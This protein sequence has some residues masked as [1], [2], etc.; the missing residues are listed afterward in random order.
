MFSIRA[1]RAP[2]VDTNEFLPWV[3]KYRPKTVDD[4]AY[5]EDVIATLKRSV[6]TQNLPHLLF[7]GPP[8]TGKTS[9][10]LAIGR[11]LFGGDLYKSRILELNA[12]DDRGINVIRTKIKNFSQLTSRSTSSK[13]PPYK[14]LILDE[15]DSMTPEAQAALRRTME[16]YSKTTR[17]CL[18]CNYVSRIIEPLASRCAKFRFKP[19]NTSSMQLRLKTICEQEGITFTTELG[20]KLSEVSGGDMR[21]AITTLQSAFTLYGKD[22]NVDMVIDISG[23]V[24]DKVIEDLIKSATSFSF[25]RL[26]KAVNDVIAEGYPAMQI[27]SQIFDVVVTSPQLT[28]VHKANIAEA[29]AQA[30]KNLQ[31]GADESLQ[32]M[33]VL[34]V[35]LKESSNKSH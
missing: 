14:L 3:E 26:Q 5:Q 20:N 8:G 15:A 32:L 9:T 10:I 29:L 4:V 1:P 6:E 18:I 28:N 23:L 22:V 24:P 27:L 17:F 30:D 12:S 16:H 33:S 7:Y 19:L 11:D 2:K 21:K 31:D 13:V 35:Y 25:D 34:S